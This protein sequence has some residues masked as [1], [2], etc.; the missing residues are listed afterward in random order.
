MQIHLLS[1]KSKM[2]ARMSGDVDSAHGN[3]YISTN[4]TDRILINIPKALYVH[5]EYDIIICLCPSSPII[6]HISFVW[7]KTWNFKHYI[8]N[9]LIMFYR[10]TITYNQLFYVQNVY[11]WI[12]I[13]FYKHPMVSMECSSIIQSY[14][15]EQVVI[16]ICLPKHI[17]LFQFGCNS[18]SYMWFFLWYPNCP[19]NRNRLGSCT[20]NQIYDT[21]KIIN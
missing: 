11:S 20:N 9:S 4:N 18:H 21:L 16:F 15:L 19:Q 13:V 7:Q 10:V 1:P 14:K 6:A 2:A 17:I 8:W 3:C 5:T 12:N